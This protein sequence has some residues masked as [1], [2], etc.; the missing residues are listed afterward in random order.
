MKWTYKEEIVER[1]KKGAAE[2]ATVKKV[3]IAIAYGQLIVDD[4]IYAFRAKETPE[5]DY[6]GEV[7]VRLLR[8]GDGK[9]LQVEGEQ[10]RKILKK[11]S[12]EKQKAVAEGQRIPELNAQTMVYL[13]SMNEKAVK[14]A[15]MRGQKRLYQ[16]NY[17]T[18]MKC[19]KKTAAVGSMHAMAMF[20]SYHKE[21][22]LVNPDGSPRT[23]EEK[24]A[25]LKAICAALDAKPVNELRTRDLRAVYITLGSKA[26]WKFGVARKFFDHCRGRS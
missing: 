10:R 8:P 6:V 3:K 26:Q 9:T 22:L 23:T 25:V 5:G 20:G 7:M 17:A 13:N 18:L 1:T 19:L 15:V 14:R 2:E 12:A 21:F 11:L 4:C 24:V 16:K